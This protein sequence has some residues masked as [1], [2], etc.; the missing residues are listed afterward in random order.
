MKTL[1]VRLVIIL[2]IAAVV[3]GGGVVGLRHFQMRGNAGFFLEQ[4]NQAEMRARSLRERE[5]FEQA[6]TEYEEAVTKYGWFVNLNR[7]DTDAWEKLAF[8]QADLAQTIFETIDSDDSRVIQRKALGESSRANMRSLS[9]LERVLRLDA[10]RPDARRK[11][12]NLATAFGRYSDAIEHLEGFFETLQNDAELLLLLGNCRERLRQ[13]EEAVTALSRAIELSPDS[14]DA[15]LLLVRILASENRLNRP[16]KADV[17]MEKMVEANPESSSAHVSFGRYLMGLA[18]LDSLDTIRRHPLMLKRILPSMIGKSVNETIEGLELSEDDPERITLREKQLLLVDAVERALSLCDSELPLDEPETL[19]LN[20]IGGVKVS[21]AE[22]E[23]LTAARDEA[24]TALKDELSAEDVATLQ[25]AS[26]HGVLVSAMQSTLKN[27]GDGRILAESLRNAVLDEVM[28]HA[29]T[30]RR[31]AAENREVLA[32]AQE[33]GVLADAIGR[34]LEKLPT[35]DLRLTANRNVLE[36]ALDDAVKGLAL[37]ADDED[38]RRLAAKQGV[39]LIAVQRAMRDSQ[40]VSCNLSSIPEDQNDAVLADTAERT[41]ESR[42]AQL[43]GHDRD[44]LLLVVRYVLLNKEFDRAREIIQQGLELYPTSSQM[45]DTLSRVELQLGDRQQAIAALRRGLEAIEDAPDLLWQLANLLIDARNLEEAKEVIEDLVATE[46]GGTQEVP[47]AAVAAAYLKA[48]IAFAESQW[49]EAAE[50]FTQVRPTLSDQPRLLAQAE[51]LAGQCYQRLSNLDKAQLA[52]Q[53]ALVINPRYTQARAALAR[54]LGQSGKT[55]D[56][57]DQFKGLG[58]EGLL[59]AARI[60]I[61]RNLRQ[62]ESQQDW[63]EVEQTLR[64]AASM[65]PES[66]D[67]IIMSAEVLAAQGRV[68]RATQFLERARK[69]DPENDSFVLA[70]A[71]LA[72][73]EED[74]KQAEKLLDE[75]EQTYGDKLV[76]RLARGQYLV[77]RYKQAAADRVKQLAGNTDHFKE[78]ERIKLVVGLVRL[79]RQEEIWQLIELLLQQGDE[80]LGDH[81]QLRLARAEY[82]ANRYRAEAAERIAKLAQDVDQFD[83]N[84]QLQLFEG[85]LSIATQIGDYEHAKTFCELLAEKRPHNLRIL[86]MLF[87]NAFRTQDVSGMDDTLRKIEVIEGQG[88][89]W[90]FSQAAR[91]SLQVKDADDARLDQAL[92]H[93]V[94]AEKE[95]PSWSRVSLLMAA[96]YDQKRDYATALKRYLK[97]IEMGE[98][99]P[100]AIHRTAQLLAQRGR[101]AEARDTIRKAEIRILRLD[102]LDMRLAHQVGELDEALQLAEKIVPKS[103]NYHDHIFLG[104]LCQAKAREA[105]GANQVDEARTYLKNAHASLQKAVELADDVPETWVAMVQFFG[106]LKQTDEA[107]KAIAQAREKLSADVLPLALAR[108]YMAMDRDKQAAAEF[109]KALEAGP[110][111]LDAVRAAIRFYVR[112]KEGASARKQINRILSGDLKAPLADQLWARRELARMIARKGDFPSRQKALALIQENLKVSPMS[113]PDLN[114]SALLQGTSPA[115]LQREA[116]IKTLE[117]LKNPSVKQAFQLAQLHYDQG[118]W[119]KANDQML[120]LLSEH[121]D[122]PTYTARY[123]GWLLDRDELDSADLWIRTLQRNAPNQ[124]GTT[125]LRARWLFGRG[126]Y[127]EAFDLLRGFVSKRDAQPANEATRMRLV[128]NSL[129]WYLTKLDDPEQKDLQNRFAMLADT[130]YR[131]YV[132]SNPPQGLFLASF[133]ARRGRLDE[134]LDIMEVMQKHAKPAALAQTCRIVLTHANATKKQIQR[135]EKIVKVA[136]EL[137]PGSTALTIVLADTQIA[138]GQYD[139]A[140]KLYR[141]YLESHEEDTTAMNNLSLLLALRGIKLDEALDLINQAIELA[142]PVAAILDSRA[143]VHMARRKPDEALADLKTAIDDKT[144]PVRV[145]HRAQAYLQKGDR[146]A[147][148]KAMQEAIDLGLARDMLQLLELPVHEKLMALI[149]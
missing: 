103:E 117:S 125:S 53:R 26:K 102:R 120:R 43:E 58:F 105:A 140:E 90:H 70:L 27:L 96:I 114:E 89:Q 77:R 108:C 10:D 48:R 143:S 33:H 21:A 99:N 115:R 76:L 24:L 100:G 92:E 73:K 82:L 49:R 34:A 69:R 94:E 64:Q 101:Y 130:L 47:P 50:G 18:G 9:S 56:A 107:E 131:R 147:A 42:S 123:V 109:A 149:Q 54:V 57:I 128:A 139:A 98:R 23:A 78:E 138:Q 39:L 36:E 60:M 121:N 74:W 14:V 12:V 13:D 145:F 3:L 144:T 71:S 141:N 15:Y 122:Q 41:A 51:F 29:E 112:T 28:S 8:L 119:Q 118:D 44:A 63:S 135:G 134:A 83:E 61:A 17:W 137:H 11:A 72:Q 68:P 113:T 40:L 87:E 116:A 46:S 126:S 59:N 110:E 5:D 4:A 84:T 86:S 62:D 66:S 38:G 80:Q 88:P 95:R 75:A 106:P 129:E 93:L 31:L 146:E 32:T 7:E 133:L 136:R 67:V 124:F 30:A 19:L 45:H 20:S 91:L 148:G 25:A 35:S 81:I 104:Q 6:R 1:N 55:D 127:E 111:D 142:G 52:F 132:R 79:A 16:E 65:N 37:P 85:L 2:V 97:A 22:P